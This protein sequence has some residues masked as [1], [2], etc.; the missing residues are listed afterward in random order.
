MS[1]FTFTPTCEAASAHAQSSPIPT[2]KTPT[3]NNNNTASI[4]SQLESLT[5]EKTKHRHSSSASTRS[6]GSNSS[7][8]DE[9]I[10]GTGA[11]HGGSFSSSGQEPN[12]LILD[13]NNG[14]TIAIEGDIIEFDRILSSHWAI[15]LGDG[16]VVHV[17]GCDPDG[18]N[19]AGIGHQGE[20]PDDEVATV[21]RAPLAAVAG[22]S[23]CRVN[24]KLLRAKE[25]GMLPFHNE[26]VVRKALSKVGS[27]VPYNALQCNTEHY[28]TEW[29][30]G[31]RWSDQAAV[32]LSSFGA[33]RRQ[34]TNSLS[35]GH[36]LFVNTLNEV[37]NS[38]AVTN[39]GN[40]A[41]TLATS[42]NAS[43][44]LSSITISPMSPRFS[45]S[46]SSPMPILSTSRYRQMSTDSAMMSAGSL[47]KNSILASRGEGRGTPKL[48]RTISSS[49]AF[50]SSSTASVQTEL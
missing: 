11:G 42:G 13:A 6:S 7:S 1:T 8:V 3:S 23:F 24:N 21:Q 48:T 26:I 31:Q 2:P 5:F 41:S 39:A 32:S 29:K 20:V 28:V 49:A 38:P 17:S 4:E 14:S 36:T 45:S 16:E 15:Y 50:S 47:P 34:H 10:G 9:G 43:P 25:R 46:P 33:L 35:E 30:Y 40:T 22:D 12:E 19:G 18:S 37:L 27:T 44:S